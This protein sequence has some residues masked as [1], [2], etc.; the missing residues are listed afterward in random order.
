MWIV[1]Y[2]LYIWSYIDCTQRHRFPA[3]QITMQWS[4][5]Q[6]ELGSVEFY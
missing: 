6:P 3:S 2:T 1:E 4:M 5:L